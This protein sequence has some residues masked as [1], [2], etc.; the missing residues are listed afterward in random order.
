MKFE[1][2]IL[3]VLNSIIIFGQTTLKGNLSSAAS[4][5]Y[6]NQI[7]GSGFFYLK[8]SNFYLVTAAHVLYK[9]DSL[10]NILNDLRYSSISIMTY[11]ENDYESKFSNFNI[12]LT[13][14]EII[15][16]H[17][18]KDIC[19]VKM[20][21]IIKQTNGLKVSFGDHIKTL[22]NGGNI[23][24]FNQN[25]II[26]FKDL[27]QG[28]EVRILGYPK[29][30]DLKKKNGET[31]FDFQFPIISSGVISGISRK[32][33]NIITSAPVYYGNSGGA[34]L[35]KLESFSQTKESITFSTDYMLI[36]VVTNFIPF[37]LQKKDTVDRIDISNSGYSIV[38]PIDYAIEL[39]K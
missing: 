12:N 33:G 30:L 18:T 19:V 31:L 39:M 23:T 6:N 34:V 32:L 29:Y 26:Q 24:S 35:S 3:L 7:I 36:G 1:I 11:P 27:E 4:I 38:I 14:T 9:T 5:N 28:S 13:K 17:S 25:R 22:K 15:K 37:Y 8:D 21:E 16:K 20:G 2:L 10:E